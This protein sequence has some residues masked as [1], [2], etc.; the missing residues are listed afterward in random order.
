MPL[1]VRL[2]AEDLNNRAGNAH[3][4]RKQ[5]KKIFHQKRRTSLWVFAMK[6]T[7]VRNLPKPSNT[8]DNEIGLRPTL[9][10]LLFPTAK[11]LAC[12]KFEVGG[13][14]MFTESAFNMY[15]VDIANFQ[16][17]SIGHTS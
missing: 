15:N 8:A 12:Q 10:K 6:H 14:S 9:K 17:K 3:L 7:T 16:Y 11:T 4:L 13:G 5:I 1:R 2:L